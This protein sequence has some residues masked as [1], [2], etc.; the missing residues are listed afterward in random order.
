[1]RRIIF[2]ALALILSLSASGCGSAA[3]PLTATLQAST[4]ATSSQTPSPVPTPSITHSVTPS[5]P[6]AKRKLTIALFDGPV[7]Y[8]KATSDQWV[9]PQTG[10]WIFEGDQL[11]TA[12]NAYVSV[13]INDRSGFILGPQSQVSIG[14][15]SL[16]FENP[17]TT[18]DLQSGSLLAV[19]AEKN[20]G[21]GVFLIK[22]DQADAAIAASQPASLSQDSGLASPIG[23]PADETGSMIVKIQPG[24]APEDSATQVGCLSGKG[25]VSI[26]NGKQTA[27]QAGEYVEVAAGS[28]SPQPIPTDLQGEANQLGSLKLGALINILTGIPPATPATSTATITPI[29]TFTPSKTGQKPTKTPILG[30][31]MPVPTH[32][33]TTPD[34]NATPRPDGLTPEE[35]ANAGHHKYFYKCL[36][37]GTCGCSSPTFTLDPTIT[38]T[39]NSVTLEGNNVFITF[40]KQ[41]PNTYVSINGNTVMVIVFYIDGFEYN[42]T[43]NGQTCLYQDYFLP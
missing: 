11:R 40:P 23:F 15:F 1:M 3:T 36:A 17:H 13:Q 25:T 16:D 27:L 26:P 31:P 37:S 8:Q 5:L 14:E 2:I 19:V 10:Q 38:F 9:V 42:V 29:R 4:T 32:R 33:I 20:L 18:L 22:T 41:M 12:Q 39:T 28:D 7:E 34:P 35:A 6:V 21:N 43:K 24:A 30:T